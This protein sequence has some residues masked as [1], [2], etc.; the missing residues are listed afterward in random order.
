MLTIGAVERARPSKRFN[1]ES[2]HRSWYSQAL[3]LHPLRFRVVLLDSDVA[4][5][6]ADPPLAASV[7]AFCVFELL[8]DG[9]SVHALYPA[10]NGPTG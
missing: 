8:P 5:V 4:V 1:T 6:G 7:R 3:A 10:R 9:P 2:G